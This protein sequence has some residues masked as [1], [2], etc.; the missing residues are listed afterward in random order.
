[1]ADKLAEHV[2]QHVEEMPMLEGFLPMPVL[3][4][5]RFKRWD[6]ILN[7]PAPPAEQKLVAAARHFARGLALAATGRLEDAVNERKTLYS[8]KTALPE[9]AM[10]SPLNPAQHVL[11]IAVGVLDAQVALARADNKAALAALQGAVQAEDA[12][13]YAE[14]A[15][16]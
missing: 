3:V 9:K 13:A 1:A 4:L 15:D 14:P 7:I 10:Y 5:A 8:I 12:L 16:W 11:T 6:D 2:K